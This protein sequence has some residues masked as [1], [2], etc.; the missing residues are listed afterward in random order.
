MAD[1]RWTSEQAAAVLARGDTLLSANA[2]TG[3]TTTVVGK[4]LWL[5]GLDAGV[6]GGTGQPLPRCQ[7]PCELREIAAITFTEK[8]AHDL[9]R[10]LRQ[11]IERSERADELR[12]EIDRA[13]IGTIHSFCASLLREHA[14]RLEID[15][16]FEILDEREARS[17]QDELIRQ[18]VLER[19][20]AEDDGVA[21]LFQDF[22][23]YGWEHTDGT[24]DL[25]R[26][27]LRDLRW[28]EQRYVDWCEGDT[29]AFDLE[30]LRQLSPHDPDPKDDAVLRHCDALHRLARLSLDRW[31]EYLREENLRD[32]DALILDTRDLLTGDRAEAALR[33]IRSRYRILIID[34]FQDTDRAQADIAFAIGRGVERPQLYFVGDPKQSIYRFRGADISVWS[35]VT[36]A[37]EGDGDRLSLT[38]NFRS[39]P[40][41]IRY[42]NAVG[43]AAIE[44]TGEALEG[45][46]PGSRVRYSDLEPALGSS[47]TA[48]VEFLV[49]DGSNAE[50]RRTAEGEQVARRIRELVEGRELV[51]D[52][53]TEE[54]RPCRFRD[55]AVLY[56][57]RTG[58]EHYGRMLALHGVPVFSSAQGGLTE[59]QE[60]ADVVNALRL[61]DN[62]AD[63]LAAFAFLRSPFVGLRDEVLARIAMERGRRSLLYQARQYAENGEWWDAPE[64][65]RVAEIERRALRDGVALVDELVALAARLPLDELTE[66]LLDGSGYRLHLLMMGENREALGN[67]QTLLRIAEQHRRQ[68]LG[69]FLDIWD[70]WDDQDSGLPQAPLY[71]ADDDVV[72]L[73]TVHRA[74]G[75]EWPVVFLIDTTSR[76]KPPR[77]REYWTDHEHGPLL[78]P[79]RADMGPRAAALIERRDLEE[80]AEEA[81]LVYVATTRA[82]DRLVV[83]GPPAA[84]KPDCWMRWLRAGEEEPVV[85]GRTEAEELEPSPPDPAPELEWL[86]RLRAAEAPALAK[87][88]DD[89]PLRWLTSATELMMREDDRK[90]WEQRYVHGVEPVWVFA[91]G[92]GDGG[93]GSPGIPANIRGTVIH[94]VLERYPPGPLE[95]ARREAELARV[96]DEV[97][98]ELDAPELEPYLQPGQSYREAL[99]QEI[100]RVVTSDEWAW[101]TD[102]EHHRELEFL[103]LV[104]PRAWR[105]GAFDLLKPGDPAW[106]IDFK[107]HEIPAEQAEGTAREYRRQV[108]IY[109]EAAGMVGPVRVRLHFTHPGVVV[110]VGHRVPE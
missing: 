31:R 41:L 108:Q 5:L 64:D 22:G 25:T 58:I 21:A 96:L 93:A 14:L 1:F 97:V 106:V 68:P 53:E 110:E 67:L 11:E 87:P 37:L 16:T 81:R 39:Q 32:Y 71:S 91:P 34:E 60:V 98:V 75:L 44:E 78:K 74:K 102:G 26:A 66:R 92:T 24:V 54:L 20:E 62:P 105:V 107:T 35:R 65:G 43:E 70:A 59:Q 85:S 49:A 61:I 28:H 38:R 6:D 2:G 55:I 89:P 104:E 10:K 90:Q 80:K 48:G 18:V 4:V 23:L 86:D 83:T 7:A 94:G 77:S 57:T 103:H 72:T 46:L 30:A 101:Y 109:R 79:S 100:A 29:S 99:E 45:E 33:S 15:P 47:G 56:R 8:A 27:V 9:K 42:L 50:G 73:T 17:A 19:L 95:Q 3:K 69:T 52:P 13:S 40:E 88:V 82:R 63:D 51:V 76:M 36:D 84:P 12:W